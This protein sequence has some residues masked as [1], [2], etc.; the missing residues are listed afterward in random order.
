MGIRNV[1]VQKGLQTTSIP[2]PE[3]S[4]NHERPNQGRLIVIGVTQTV[5]KS[6]KVV[7]PAAS[8]AI[9]SDFSC[10]TAPRSRKRPTSALA[11]TIAVSLPRIRG[12]PRS[13][14]LPSAMPRSLL[15]QP[16]Y[17]YQSNYCGPR[18]TEESGET[19]LHHRRKRR[20]HLKTRTFNS[21]RNSLRSSI[22]SRNY[23]SCWF[24]SYQEFTSQ[25]KPSV[26]LTKK[27]LP[28]YHR[29]QHHYEFNHVD[30]LKMLMKSQSTSTVD[31]IPA[32]SS[33][34][35]VFVG[36]L[37]SQGTTD[38][39]AGFFKNVK[40]SAIHVKRATVTPKDT[41]YSAILTILRYLYTKQTQQLIE[42]LKDLTLTSTMSTLYRLR[43]KTNLTRFK[44]M[45]TS[46]QITITPSDN[47][48]IDPTDNPAPELAEDP[49]VGKNPTD[50]DAPR[51]NIL[52][53]AP[54][55]INLPLKPVIKPPLISRGSSYVQ[56]CFINPPFGGIMSLPTCDPDETA[57]KH[58]A[59]PPR[60]RRP[61]A[62]LNAA[63]LPIN[64]SIIRE[65]VTTSAPYIQTPTSKPQNATPITLNL[66]SEACTV[67]NG[68]QIPDN[69]ITRPSFDTEMK[70]RV[71]PSNDAQSPCDISD[72]TTS[73]SVLHG[74]TGQPA[75]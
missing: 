48:P 52:A 61:T 14:I 11:A 25:P 10:P 23:N 53:K 50:T 13:S 71:K 26:H 22:L 27:P 75:N 4:S 42:L 20:N 54:P 7:N 15:L 28:R 34:Q 64:Q 16:Q 24:V 67:Q 1:F 39:L 65:P 33:S 41:H 40:L 46:T 36:N 56:R 30:L 60:S 58:S 19:N 55:S 17:Q 43:K 32:C 44:T 59:T 37:N 62:A 2:K 3:S 49:K 70:Q 69:T 68:T 29:N 51:R 72:E 8:G 73:M 38:Y 31:N 18:Y 21:V 6:T 63:D 66:S 12:P 5:Q 74:A 57:G 9:R 47:A 35:T 45:I